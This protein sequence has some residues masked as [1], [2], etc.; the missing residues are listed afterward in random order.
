M[1]CGLDAPPGSGEKGKGSRPSARQHLRPGGQVQG[2][3]EGGEEVQEQGTCAPGVAGTSLPPEEL[4]RR[5]FLAV[6]ERP[7][8]EAGARWGGSFS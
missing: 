3:L 5:A 2:M 8:A 7:W 1:P 4:G 6:W